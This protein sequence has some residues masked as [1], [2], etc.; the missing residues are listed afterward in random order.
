MSDTNV[1]NLVRANMWTF[2]HRFA[3]RSQIWEDG[4]TV[5]Q[6]KA[7]FTQD[8]KGRTT[9]TTTTEDDFVPFF[10]LPWIEDGCFIGQIPNQGPQYFF[11]GPLNGCTFAVDRNWYHPT[12]GHANRQVELTTDGPRQREDL[13]RAMRTSRSFFSRRGSGPTL[14]FVE[15]YRRRE[16]ERVGEDQDVSYNVFGYRGWLGWW[17]MYQVIDRYDQQV[18]PLRT[19]SVWTFF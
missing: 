16:I 11:T 7:L 15:S 2:V 12:V 6:I 18:R 1:N 17:F 9:M 14:T 10:Y 8:R 5:V 19:E 4:D 3:V 13:E